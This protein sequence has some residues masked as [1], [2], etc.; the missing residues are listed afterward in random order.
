MND[1]LSEVIVKKPWGYEYLCYENEDVAVWFLH[2][3]YNQ[4]TSMHC[5]S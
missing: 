2:I 4:K 5:H 3:E 1:I